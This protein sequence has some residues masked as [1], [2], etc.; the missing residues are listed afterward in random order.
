MRFPE[1]GTWKVKRK[2]E[3][4]GDLHVLD[5]S[6]RATNQW[7]ADGPVLH[8]NPTS[9]G[10]NKKIK[11]IIN[12][13]ESKMLTK[14]QLQQKT[15]ILMFVRNRCFLRLNVELQFHFYFCPR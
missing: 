10:Q 7:R 13:E 11:A 9:K 2:E 14:R 5:F 4:N 3:A 12:S 1:G 6:E 15:K 8:R